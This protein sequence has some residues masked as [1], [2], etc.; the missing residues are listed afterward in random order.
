MY[1]YQLDNIKRDLE[2]IIDDLK[3]FESSREIEQAIIN[4]EQGILWTSRY[5]EKHCED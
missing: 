1:E 2:G 5:Y 3:R 4:I